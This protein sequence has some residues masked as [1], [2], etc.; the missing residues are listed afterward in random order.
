MAEPIIKQS[1]PIV[2]WGL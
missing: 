2:S 1:M